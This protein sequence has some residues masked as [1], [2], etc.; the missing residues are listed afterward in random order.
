MGIKFTP[1]NGSG[2][3]C[4]GGGTGTPCVTSLCPPHTN[5]TATF[6]D[7]TPNGTLS[8][9]VTSTAPALF[10]G[11]NLWTAGPPDWTGSAGACDTSL[12][13]VAP[14]SVILN[15]V[16]GGTQVVITIGGVRSY[17]IQGCSGGFT[18]LVLDTNT[19]SPVL[20]VVTITDPTFFYSTLTI[21]P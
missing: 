5:L 1:K 21:S 7:P 15:C 12:N 11:G 18:C 19:C 3:G 13:S 9:C 17:S 6:S 16:A 14:V 10:T 4:C 8:G 20:I 2:C